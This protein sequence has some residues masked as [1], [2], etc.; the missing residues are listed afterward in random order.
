MSDT[1]PKGQSRCVSRRGIL[2]LVAALTL[3]CLLKPLEIYSGHKSERVW[4][5][6]WFG[7]KLGF[8]TIPRLPFP[9]GSGYNVKTDGTGFYLLLAQ[10]MSAF[11]RRA[12]ASL[13]STLRSTRWSTNEFKA[14]G[15]PAD[16][17]CLGIRSSVSEPVTYDHRSSKVGIPGVSSSPAVR[18]HSYSQ[19]HWQSGWEWIT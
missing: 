7:L 2:V 19:T 10:H 11:G 16:N 8:G 3:L 9:G 1:K 4:E 18:N 14:R 13:C 5:W 12:L 6:K 15:C 17:I